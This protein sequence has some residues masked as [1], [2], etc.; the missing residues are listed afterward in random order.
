MEREFSKKIRVFAVGTII[1]LIIS[2]LSFGVTIYNQFNNKPNTCVTK[3]SSTV[4]FNK[5]GKN[6]TKAY[7]VIKFQPCKGSYKIELTQF[8]GTKNTSYTVYAKKQTEKS[9]KKYG[10][11]KLTTKG[12]AKSVNLMKANNNSTVYY[13]KVVKDN[14]NKVKS[15]VKQ[16]IIIK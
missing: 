7:D 5:Q 15:K 9:Y 8:S 4:E 1:A 6:S 13:V 16:T 11:V 14:N 12:A 2:G 3:S 10:T